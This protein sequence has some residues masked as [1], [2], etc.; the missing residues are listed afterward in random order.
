MALLYQKGAALENSGAPKF[1]D[2]KSQEA[3]QFYKQFADIRSPFYTWNQTQHY[4]LDAFYEGTLAMMINYSWQYPALKQKNAKL[5]IGVAPLPQ[6][7]G[8]VTAN[9]ANYW[10]YGVAK[11]KSYNADVNSKRAPTPENFDKIRTHEAWQFLKFF[12]FAKE[13]QGLRFQNAI[14]GESAD[15]VMPVDP[16]KKYLEKTGKPAA[17]RDLIA[18]QQTDIVL[19]PFASGNLI[20][21]NWIH[22]SVTA[23][24]GVL[25]E[26]ITSVYTGSVS[27][28]DALA[29]ANRRIETLL[30]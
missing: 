5:N 24:E 20:A 27:A 18:T 15:I 17:R 2:T 30:R 19:G 9:Q 8:G 29:I 16:A 12:A 14:T 28:R 26:L 11:N 6:F 1:T 22:Q 23:V 21:K 10:A 4:S 7:E 13:K 25:A 3:M